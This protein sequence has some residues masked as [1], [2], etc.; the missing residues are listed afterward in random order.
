MNI[1]SAFGDKGQ[2][3]DAAHMHFPHEEGMAEWTQV[4]LITEL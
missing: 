2:F 4:R 1:L 3:H